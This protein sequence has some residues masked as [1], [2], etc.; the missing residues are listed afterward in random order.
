M[1]VVVGKCVLLDTLAIKV[2]CHALKFA[3]VLPWTYVTTVQEGIEDTDEYTCSK[4]HCI[5]TTMLILCVCVCLVTS[6]CLMVKLVLS[7]RLY[8][9]LTLVC[10]KSSY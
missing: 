8:H 7:S 10:S 9:T 4:L 5:E 1:D 3:L 2:E 6:T